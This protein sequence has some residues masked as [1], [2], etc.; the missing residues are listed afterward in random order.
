MRMRSKKNLIPRLEKVSY[1][2][3]TKPEE[4]K[5]KWKNNIQQNALHV[6]IG[7]GKGDF[8]CQNALNNP[9]IYFVAIELVKEALIMA[10]EKAD[11]LGLT[12]VRFISEDA[13][14]IKEYF[15]LW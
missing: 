13:R 15:R 7:C 1:L 4:K 6:E 3:E 12:N 11:K 10:L 2:L 8:I 5:G 14:N 9:D